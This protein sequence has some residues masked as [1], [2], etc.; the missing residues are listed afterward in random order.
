[1]I[2]V[3]VS[4]ADSA[5]INIVIGDV[6]LAK[7]L[8]NNS[9]SVSGEQKIQI[10][11][12]YVEQLLRSE[13]SSTKYNPER[14]RNIECLHDYWTK[15][16]FPTGE[17]YHEENMK[18]KPNFR[19]SQGNL[20]AVGYLVENSSYGGKSLVDVISEKHSFDYIKDMLDLPE[21]V[22]WQEKSGLSVNELAMIQPTYEFKWITKVD[23][24]LADLTTIATHEGQKDI[25]NSVTDNVARLLNA[26]GANNTLQRF[27][28]EEMNPKL[29]DWR[30]K[31]FGKS[32][33]ADQLFIKVEKKSFGMGG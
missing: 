23:N 24:I 26:G 10:H 13:Q 25:E 30:E 19:D 7:F 3:N 14:S 20:C 15:G 2:K 18:R 22:A 29:I 11:L 9:T 17:H 28:K 12:E 4:S 5:L 33:E 6:S 8:S 32:A 31:Y 21:L 16:I 27:A 1:M